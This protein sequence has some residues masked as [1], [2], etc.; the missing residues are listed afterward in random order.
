MYRLFFAIFFSLIFKYSAQTTAPKL[1]NYQGIARDASGVPITNPFDIQFIINDASSIVH[2][3]IQ[4]GISPNALGLFNTI[5]GK[6]P[7][8]LSVTAWNN[9]PFTLDVFIKTTGTFS[10]VGTQTLVSVP[11]SL[12]A[13]FA[14]NVPSS[15]TNNILT[16]GAN[17]YSLNSG[18][19]ITPT[20][21]GNG[22]A[23]VSSTTGPLYS[24]NVPTP[25]LNYTN[26]G[27]ILTLTQGSFSSSTTL[28]G[29]GSS[30]IS[31]VGQ[32]NAIVTPTFGSAFT[33]SVAP[34]V[35]STASNILSLSNGGG[36]VVMPA[37]TI[38]GSTGISAIGNPLSGYTITNIAAVPIT[39]TNGQN[40]NLSGNIISAPTNSLTFSNPSNGIVTNGLSSSAFTIPSPTLGFGPGINITGAWPTPTIAVINGTNI[41]WGTYG[42]SG[43]NPTNNFVGTTDAADLAF[44]TGNTVRATILGGNGNIG[45]GTAVP[46]T[47]L[48][49]S[50]QVTIADGSQGD[51]KILVSNATGNATWRSSPAA[52]A[53][54]GFNNTPVI[55]TSAATQM[56]TPLMPFT[57]QFVN[58]EIQLDLHSLATSGTF[59]GGAT[60]ISYELRIDGNTSAVSTIH[61]IFTTNT[62]EYID[63]KA[64]FQGLSAGAHTVSVWAKTNLG[65]T[66]S[67]YLDPGGWGGKLIL[68][69][70]N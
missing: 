55:V 61:Y 60:Y 64:V 48:H 5:I 38:T 68:K 35:L 1:I 39:Y 36:S 8:T 40:I 17:S 9:G 53:F 50:G 12:F 15:Y 21:V 63:L 3:E 23:I 25:S 13:G 34:Q 58:S 42:N 28:T 52:I 6:P 57:K 65:N 27:N 47:K 16:I 2:N 66:S 56:G 22:L 18:A 45:I 4:T 7:N 44:R 26:I 37:T 30:T 49:I 29:T 67:I 46:A 69:E 31:M 70:I 11:F 41:P 62:T 10:L 19:S 24:V 51:G 59:A 14:G 54:G 32:G 20:I 43:T 33:V